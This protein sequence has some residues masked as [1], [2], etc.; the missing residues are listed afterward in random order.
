MPLLAYG[1]I[2]VG[3]TKCGSNLPQN[4]IVIGNMVIYVP[5]KEANAAGTDP[6][7][8]LI[9]DNGQLLPPQSTIHATCVVDHLT[10]KMDHNV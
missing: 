10:T 2:E 4:T 6:V 5:Q 9:H 7:G 3:A 1:I 8:H